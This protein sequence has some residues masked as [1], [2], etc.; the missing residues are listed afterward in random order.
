MVSFPAVP[1]VP[2][3]PAALAVVVVAFT[4]G[5]L[6]V[7]VF[8]NLL[9]AGPS[10][11]YLACTIRNMS[12]LQRFID[13]CVSFGLEVAPVWSSELQE[14]DRGDGD[15]A[16]GGGGSSEEP[17]AA[18]GD[19]EGSSASDPRSWTVTANT[20]FTTVVTQ[21]CFDRV[22]VLRIR[23]SKTCIPSA[24]DRALDDGDTWALLLP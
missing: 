16:G 22:R 14:G 6:S 17:G 1:A 12:T 15:G 7:C 21:K 3:V 9:P 23:A 4:A 19:R 11:A 13:M 18:D 20:V 8:P 24:S 5:L 2:A 10:E